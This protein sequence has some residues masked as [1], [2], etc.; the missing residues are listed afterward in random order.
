[1][2]ETQSFTFEKRLEVPWGFKHALPPTVL[3]ALRSL[4][5]ELRERAVTRWR[6]EVLPR[7]EEARRRLRAQARLLEDRVREEREALARAEREAYALLSAGAPLGGY[8]RLLRARAQALRRAVAPPEREAYA[9]AV[10][11]RLGL[12]A[13][14]PHAREVA[15]ALVLVA[16]EV[17][18]ARGYHARTAEVAF[19]L[20]QQVLAAALW[21]DARP[22][23]ARKR[24]QRALAR[25]AGAGLVAH[26]G[27]VGNARDRA[28]GGLLGWRDG[29][30]FRVRLAPGR[31]APIRAEELAHPWRDLEADIRR[32]RTA[33]R[34]L[35]G[36]V[37]QSKNT[38]EK[39]SF[40]EMLLSW[41]LAPVLKPKAPLSV[42][43]TAS[44]PPRVRLRNALMDVRAAERPLRRD[45]VE[46]AARLAA[47]LLADPGSLRFYAAL[48]WGALR[49]L[50]RGADPFPALAAEMERA[51]V[52]R[53]EGFARRAGAL[54]TA[55]LRAS[56]LLVQLLAAPPY[57]VA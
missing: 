9:E 48:L 1:M 15:R 27:R 37:S 52:D 43:D 4:P 7:E 46:A 10:L 12:P 25:L 11:A 39:G 32:G 22:E 5:P 17:G 24:I 42:W 33:R 8:D 50:D 31:A 55:R 38:K 13:L 28:T 51:L 30:V 47:H 45:L 57:R 29:T 21:P 16:L 49:Q 56:G 36:G 23:T 35:A 40:L 41:A 3:R 26:R 44:E 54:L 14:S 20:P 18:R 53:E 34:R 2:K 19:H 6:T